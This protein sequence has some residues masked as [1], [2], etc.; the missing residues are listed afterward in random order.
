MLSV[1]VMSVIM[2]CV[3]ML[4]DTILCVF[5]FSVVMLNVVIMTVVEP[6]KEFRYADILSQS[7]KTFFGVSFL[8]CKLY[9]FTIVEILP[10]CYETV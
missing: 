7:D 2:L 4:N 5:I 8:S 1:I 9:Q 3:V 6:E 10:H